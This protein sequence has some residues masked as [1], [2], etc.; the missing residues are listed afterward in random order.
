MT[1]EQGIKESILILGCLLA[2][3][4][5]FALVYMGMILI[6]QATYFR[7]LCLSQQCI[8]YLAV[9]VIFGVFPIAWGIVLWLVLFFVLR[10]W[11]FKGT[12]RRLVQLDADHKDDVGPRVEWISQ[13][14]APFTYPASAKLDSPDFRYSF[15][16]HLNS[17][18]ILA[19]LCLLGVAEVCTESRVLYSID[20]L[21]VATAVFVPVGK[22]SYFLAY[23]GS[24]SPF[25]MC[26]GLSYIFVA[27]TGGLYYFVVGVMLKTIRDSM[28]F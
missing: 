17:L 12:E 7:I 23:R 3:C 9:I 21:L 28:L 18:F 26:P 1:L 5:L 14:R 22:L 15:G 4:V 6:K 10:L 25:R 8:S 16:D 11:L 19:V 13:W 20:F 27:F 24:G 2:A